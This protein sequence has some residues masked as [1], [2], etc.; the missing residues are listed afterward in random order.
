MKVS[1]DVPASKATLTAALKGL[2]A[3]DVVLLR[4]KPNCPKLYASGVRYRAEPPGRE[5]W[6]TIPRV[7]R[8]GVGDCEDLAAWRAAE[9][10]VAGVAAQ[11]IVIRSGPRKFH[12]VVRWPDGRIEDPSKKLGMKG[13]P[14][15]AP[16]GRR[17]K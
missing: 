7:L 4:R 15:R 5:R 16:K 6:L 3:V 2:T 8:A 17:R 14:R 1:F 11:A 10:Q 12:A 9:L 13:G